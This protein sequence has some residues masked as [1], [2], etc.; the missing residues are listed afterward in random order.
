M[1]SSGGATQYW[2]APLSTSTHRRRSPVIACWLAIAT[3]SLAASIWIGDAPGVYY[4]EVIQAGTARNF[5]ES[6]SRGRLPGATTVPLFGRPLPWMTQVYLGALKDQLLIPSF[7]LF[8][9]TPVVL[10]TTTLS[11]A[12]V[13]LLFAMLFAER[14]I[15]SGA[16][17][18]MGLLLATDPSFFFVARH[19]WG[20][21]ASGFMFRSAGLLFAIRFLVDGR[22]WT[23]LLAGSAFGLGIYNKVDVVVCLAATVCAALAAAYAGGDALR[24]RIRERRAGLVLFAT[25]LLVTAAPMIASLA[26][27]GAVAQSLSRQ[28]DSVEKLLA[29]WTTL[30][31][32]YFA[33]LMA[34][35]GRFERLFD[36]SDVGFGLFGVVALASAPT[37]VLLARRETREARGALVFVWVAFVL[38][39][40][41]MLVFPGASRIHHF[42]NVLPFPHL[43]VAAVLSVGW[44]T[45]HRLVRTTLAAVAA[46]ALV[47]SIVID[48]RTAQLITTTGGRGWWSD[49]LNA[50]AADPSLS[51]EDNLVSLD[52]G[53]HQSL[54]FLLPSDGPRLEEPFWGIR[55]IADRH[56]EWVRAGV[57]GDVYLVHAMNYDLMGYGN[58][59]LAAIIALED[60]SVS[61]QVHLDRE[62]E[63]VFW[64]V[65][66]GRPHRL[67]YQPKRGFRVE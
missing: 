44:R 61:R 63:R 10:R 45:R 18:A 5:I 47:G 42:L 16:A 20:P 41:G 32:T 8:G 25:A 2:A 21:F 17:I 36:P 9:A 48:I 30:D 58:D 3:A 53:F 34:V 4:D 23:A 29:A 26:E 31:G 22:L 39:T 56:G 52:W 40:I 13:G 11:I 66:I 51:A 43:A 67:I 62:G 59:F 12:L 46:L 24:A 55:R 28:D 49:A 60:D 64:S 27:M 50:F 6:T 57:S 65:R 37:L 15:G 38:A 35:G 54:S 7:A 19:D 14:L 1:L 33:R